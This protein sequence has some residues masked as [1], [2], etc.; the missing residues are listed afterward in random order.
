MPAG[1]T[2]LLWAKQ[3]LIYIRHVVLHR[4][5]IWKPEGECAFS[6]YFFLSAVHIPT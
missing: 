4:D 2:I 6:P 5:Y 3:G 1:V